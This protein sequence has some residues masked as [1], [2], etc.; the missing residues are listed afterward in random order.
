MPRSYHTAAVAFAIGR[1]A[2]WL[3]NVLSRHVIA[4]VPRQTRGLARAIPVDALMVL[5]IASDLCADLDLSVPRS[6]ELAHRL[7]AS[8]DGSAVLS[9]GLRIHVDLTR[10]WQLLNHRL[11]E[12]AET[13]LAPPRG[14]PP[15]ARRG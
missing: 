15:G 6:L 2:K 5:S 1:P 9:S 4:G 10:A 7:A 11:L 8:N 12:T 13:H 3:D 14:R